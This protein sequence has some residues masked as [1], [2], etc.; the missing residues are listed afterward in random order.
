[1]PDRKKI[2]NRLLMAAARE[3]EQEGEQDKALA[4][5]KQVVSHDPLAEAAWQRLMIL[6]RKGKDYAGELKIIN[7]ALQAFD[8]HNREGQRQ[9]LQENRKAARVAKSL[10]KS[11]GLMDK[12]GIVID[13]NPV[14]EKWKHRKDWV[15]ARL[16]KEKVKRR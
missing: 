10:A 8:T 12:K 9:W 7:L 1:M 14:L 15:M 6:H 2:S 5:Y 11:L 16:K 3:A 4:L 13:D